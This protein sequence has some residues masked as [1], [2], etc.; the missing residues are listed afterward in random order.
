[1]SIKTTNMS[2]FHLFEHHYLSMLLYQILLLLFFFIGTP[3]ISK[4]LSLQN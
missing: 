4:V 2:K 3:A 1:M